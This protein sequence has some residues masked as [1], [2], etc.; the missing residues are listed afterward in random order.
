MPETWT[1]NLDETTRC[2]LYSGRR[3]TVW[4]VSIRKCEQN[5][6][7]L[8]LT[9]IL[10][11]IMTILVSPTQNP[12]ISGPILI[13]PFFLLYMWGIYTWSFPTL[14]S[15]HPVHINGQQGFWETSKKRTWTYA[16]YKSLNSNIYEQHKYA[17]KINK[18]MADAKIDEKIQRFEDKIDCMIKDD[19][20]RVIICRMRYQKLRFR[21]RIV[22]DVS[23]PFFISNTWINTVLTKIG[24][25]TSWRKADNL[26]ADFWVRNERR[27]R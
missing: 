11:C 21:N 22:T 25:M 8:Q 17:A 3:W 24:S 19:M 13:K 6:S 7:E 27:D 15:L 2:G 5:T 9:K 16:I 4:T 1:S 20:I 14:F 26:A 18:S 10:D 12:S 23:F